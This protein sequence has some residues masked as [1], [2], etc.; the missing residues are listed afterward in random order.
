M[1]Q[2]DTT[3]KAG[4]RCRA[5]HTSTRTSGAKFSRPYPHGSA[6]IAA[7]AGGEIGANRQV[8]PAI[9][10]GRVKLRPTNRE[11]FRVCVGRELFLLLPRPIEWDEE[12]VE[13]DFRRA[14]RGV[15]VVA[16]H[17]SAAHEPAGRAGARLDG[18]Q[19][20]ATANRRPAARGLLRLSFRRNPVAVVQPH[21][22]GVVAGGRRREGW[23]RAAEFFRLAA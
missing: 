7:L 23:A 10:G 8:C 16:T 1:A 19:P 20:A 12:K 6:S 11:W 13:M 3:T 5:A 21:R 4:R 22:A 18:H 14:R 2:P 15:C 17:E 9:V